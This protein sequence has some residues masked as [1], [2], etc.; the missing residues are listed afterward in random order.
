VKNKF[1]IIVGAVDAI[2]ARRCSETGADY[3][4]ASSFVISAMHGLQDKGMVNINYF[5][6][7]INS[8]IKGALCPVILDFDIGGRNLSEYQAQLISLKKLSL[9]GICI[10]DEKWLKI[11]A[12]LKSS[13]RHLISPEEMVFKIIMAKKILGP[14][15]LLIARTHSLIKKESLTKLQQRIN[16]YQNGGADIISVHSGNLSFNYYQKILKKLSFQKPLLYI[17]TSSIPSFKFLESF[18]IQ[19]LLFPNQVYRMMLFPIFNF[20]KKSKFTRKEEFLKEL[21]KHFKNKKNLI[22]AN[23]I[24]EIVDE[25]NK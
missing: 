12:M 22:N 6:P 20:F 14:R 5:L 11:N 21:L 10:E 25:I 18:N 2:T 15:C 7:I 13:D 16:L 3:I 9:G 1:H 19:Y 23:E 4:W 8:L 17:V 24:F